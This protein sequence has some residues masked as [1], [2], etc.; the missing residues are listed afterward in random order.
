MIKFEEKIFNGVDMKSL[1]V[2]IILITS[3]FESELD[4]QN[5]YPLQTG[6]RWCYRI[7]DDNGFSDTACVSVMKDTICPNG[8]TYFMLSDYNYFIPSRFVRADSTGIYY[9]NESDSVDQLTFNVNM[10]I[11]DTLYSLWPPFHLIT[12]SDIDTVSLFSVTTRILNYYLDGLQVATMNLSDRFGPNEHSF[13]GDPPAPFP[14]Y[15]RSLIGCVIGDSIFGYTLVISGN[16]PYF[17]KKIYLSQNYPNPFNPSTTISYQLPVN[18]KVKLKI[19]NTL[20]QEVRTL[21][22][23]HQSS[24][25]HEAMWNGKDNQGSTVSSGIYIYRID[26]VS[27]KGRFTE[28]KKMVYI[29]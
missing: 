20:G 26:A 14:Y 27:D 10:D 24:G 18:A 15:T 22:N 8:L 7:T 2:F 17:Q 1:L 6:N 25:K 23:S 19:F 3:F 29:K 21:V 11:G 13:Y 5:Y 9:Y 12:L 28:V 16:D 4:A